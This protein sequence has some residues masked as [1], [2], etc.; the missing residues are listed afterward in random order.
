MV[1]KGERIKQLRDQLGISQTELAEHIGTSKQ[2]LYKYENDIIT[3]IPSD[4]VEALAKELKVSPAYIMGWDEDSSIPH[5]NKLIDV[6]FESIMTWSEDG[7]ARPH[8]SEVYRMH[9]ADLLLRYKLLIKRAV[10]TSSSV[11]AYLID[12]AHLNESREHPLS[13][14]QLKERYFRAELYHELND[15]VCWINAFP[16]HLSRADDEEYLKSMR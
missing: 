9:F 10:Y 1:T 2:N 15:L 3:N 4:K 13:E 5:F 12:N 7:L 16:M 11:D 14:K 6:Y 8:D